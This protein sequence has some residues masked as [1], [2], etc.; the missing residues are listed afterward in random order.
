MRSVLALPGPAWLGSSAQDPA[1]ECQKLK[2]LAHAERQLKNGLLLVVTVENVGDAGVT[3]RRDRIS[4]SW[5]L[6]D[7][8]TKVWRPII[9][10]GQGRGACGEGGCNSTRQLSNE[11][12]VQSA[13]Q[14]YVLLQPRE[15]LSQSFWTTAELLRNA[16]RASQGSQHYRVRFRYWNDLASGKNQCQLTSNWVEF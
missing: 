6:Q 1:G 13:L 14:D 12:A 11:E 8:I 3:L 4:T 16:N 10:V 15:A 9:S 7:R 5:E 2:Y